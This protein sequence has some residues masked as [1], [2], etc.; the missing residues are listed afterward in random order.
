MGWRVCSTSSCPHLVQSP[1]SKCE[2]CRRRQEDRRR[3]RGASPYNT[4]GHRRFRAQVL[5]RDPFCVCPGD[6]GSG[7]CGKHHGMCGRRSSVADHYPYERVE[8]I[9]MSLDPDDPQYGRGLCAAC[10]NAK[11]ARTRPAGFRSQ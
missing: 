10:H 8:L 7:G 2:E 4:A 11:T 3:T 6:I 9:D 5:A 1:A